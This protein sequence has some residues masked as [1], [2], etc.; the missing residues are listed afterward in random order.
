M[1]L[2]EFF[3]SIRTGFGDFFFSTITHLGEETMVIVIGL[4]F[5]WCVNKREGY[6][7]LSIG[8]LGTVVNQFLKLLCRVPRPWVKNPDFTIVE[9]A[10]AEATGYSFPSGHTQTAV[11][12][13]GGIARWEK[14]KWLRIVTVILCVLVPL[15]RMYLGVHTPWD[16]GVSILLALVMVFGLYPLMHR[17]IDKPTTMRILL[18]VMTLLA[19]GY[20]TFV[21]LYSF[22]A[23][24]D[25]HNLEHG[26][27]NAY[28]MLG[29]LL[30]LWVVFE[31]DGRFIKF[32]T[33]TTVWWVQPLKL[34]LGLIPLL[35][36]KAG[37]KA[38]LHAIMGEGYAADGVR[39]FLIVLF[40]G[41][42]WP[43]TFPL[44]QKIGKKTK[45]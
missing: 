37:L 17:A 4:I 15:S 24:V 14:A 9:S 29:C 23:D 25:V 20:L 32:D 38:P 30:G 18:I 21:S 27:K 42:V 12:I 31:V 11:G 28:T 22:P 13:F 7:L 41:C 35:G 34:V 33:A 6:Y 26:T 5:F 43:L 10:R 40:A 3:E 1:A 36:I 8:L 2:L 44:W 39:Y 19:A 45:A 16:V